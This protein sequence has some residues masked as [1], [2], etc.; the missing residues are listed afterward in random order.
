MLILR[1]ALFLGGT[2]ADINIFE[3]FDGV[4][5]GDVV[6]VVCSVGAVAGSPNAENGCSLIA[7]VGHDISVCVQLHEI[8]DEFSCWQR[9]D[10]DKDTGDREL[11]I[12]LCF[13]VGVYDAGD[14]F[15]T[16]NFFWNRI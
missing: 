3:C 5:G 16:F 12:L 6:L 9:T 14:K 1:R 8:F 11:C 7:R 13:C 10:F 15:F 4:T 2:Q